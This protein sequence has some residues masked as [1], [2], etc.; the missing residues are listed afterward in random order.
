MLTEIQDWGIS[1][2]DYNKLGW[3]S[4]ISTF[5]APNSVI[6]RF[7][8]TNVVGTDIFDVE[9]AFNEIA[10]TYIISLKSSF[11]ILRDVPFK[12]FD[13]DTKQYLRMAV[14]AAIEYCVLNNQV[15]ERVNSSTVSTPN[16]SMTSEQ[17]GW[18]TSRDML[19]MKAE[20]FVTLSELKNYEWATEDD[21]W[22]RTDKGNIII[23][24]KQDIT[25]V[26]ELL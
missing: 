5:K 6:K 13:E 3:G 10:I 17:V 21:I 11:Q 2:T 7:R 20:G 9:R 24:G 12:K 14:Y 23:L 19:G 22:T 25:N 8:T 15:W 4:A 26:K 16:F 1:L 18:L